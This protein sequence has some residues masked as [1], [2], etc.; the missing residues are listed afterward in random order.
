MKKK[1]KKKKVLI[2]VTV[3]FVIFIDVVPYILIMFSENLDE[4]TASSFRVEKKTT[5]ITSKK[6]ADRRAW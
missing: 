2:V 4:G 3:K 6:Q 1:K 5:Q